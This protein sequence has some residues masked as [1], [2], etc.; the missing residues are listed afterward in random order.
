MTYV[1][2]DLEWNQARS[3]NEVV[4]DSNG[5]KLYGEVI[6]IGA[7]KMS[8]K[9]E[10][11]SS[12]KLNVKPKYYKVI[13][14]KVK[15]LTGIEQKDLKNGEE[16]LESM[17][18]LR[19]WCGDE[20]VFLTWGPDDI[21]ILRRNI[22]MYGEKSTWLNNWFD[23]QMIYNIQTDSGENQ[24]SLQSAMEHFNIESN[25]PMHDAYNDAYYTAVV[26]KHLD[27][28]NG[29]ADLMQRARRRAILDE[30]NPL[31]CEV[32]G[33]YTARR[34]VFADRDV[35]EIKCPECGSVCRNRRKWVS[36]NNDKYLTLADCEEHG[37][38][39]IRLSLHKEENKY[40][41]TK[42][43]Y[44]AGDGAELH[45]EKKIKKEASRKKKKKRR[46]KR[47][48]PRKPLAKTDK[49]DKRE[50]KTAK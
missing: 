33:G 43:I 45:Y 20:F 22:E 47:A 35:S 24:K 49:F 11:E 50:E 28:Y 10:I 23:L 31:L 1:V 38:Y 32:Y 17:K 7:V 14:R 3:N 46:L 48:T 21:R 39:V 13:H 15:Q 29:I 34:D 26:A 42:I 37:K 27:I 6:Q 40:R 36:E 25:E 19:D 12:F 18:K 16:F 8:D 30:S 9:L 5:N 4:S 44:L 41:V 2:I